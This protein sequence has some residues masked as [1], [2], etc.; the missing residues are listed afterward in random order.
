M[1]LLAKDQQKNLMVSFNFSFLAIDA[2]TTFV[3]GSWAC[4]ANG[5]GSF[6]SNLIDPAST[7]MLRQEQ[8]GETTFIE[9][10]LPRIAEEIESLSLSDTSS[11][12]FPLGLGNSTASY[13]AI[14]HRKNVI[15]TRTAP[16]FDSYPVSD[17]DFDP[18]S[19]LLNY[20]NLTILAT[21]QS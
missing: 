20:L 10:L 19:D 7:K 5:S 12:R 15:R 8:L 18:D 6:S 9:I 21:P 1:G 14:L 4:I 11:T 2:G 17:D 13:S 3:F 16:Q